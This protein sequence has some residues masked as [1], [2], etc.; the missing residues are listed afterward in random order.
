MHGGMEESEHNA[1][2]DK[3][4]QKVL[5]LVGSLDP[6]LWRKVH[7]SLRFDAAL[8]DAN[9]G[10]YLMLRLSS[11]SKREKLKGSIAGALWFRHIAEVIRRSFEE[12]TTER[13]PEKDV[14]FGMWCPGGRTLQYGS[15]RPLDDELKC[16]PYLALHHGLFTGSVVRWYV[17]P[18]KNESTD[19][20]HGGGLPRSSDEVSVM[21]VEPRG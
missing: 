13:W 15:E 17:E 10:L 12:T 6:V 19:A 14:A 11:W 18:H 16:K 8:M 1:L 2:L 9:D 5:P 21:E 7:E 3:Y 20:R 4:R